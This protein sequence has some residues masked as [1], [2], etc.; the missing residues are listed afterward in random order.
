MPIKIE[1][2]A[3]K[4]LRRKMTILKYLMFISRCVPHLFLKKPLSMNRVTERMKFSKEQPTSLAKIIY[5]AIL[6]QPAYKNQ[7][8]IYNLKLIR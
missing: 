7:L 6:T 4:K 2:M 8:F 3:V 5:K 1:N